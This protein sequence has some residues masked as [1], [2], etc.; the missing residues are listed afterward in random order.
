L[1]IFWLLRVWFTNKYK[2]TGSPYR[3]PTNPV[4]FG[5]QTLPG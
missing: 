5:K 3:I 1:M 4:G 2:R